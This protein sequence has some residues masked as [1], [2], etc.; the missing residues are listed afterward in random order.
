M[1]LGELSLYAWIVMASVMLVLWFIQ[2]R[3]L[4]AGTVDVAWAFGT[5]AVGVWFALYGQGENDTRQWLVA[6]L[7]A[8][9]GWRLGSFLFRR[10]TSESEDGRYRYLREY[11]GERANL[12]HFA[13]FQIQAAWTLLFALPIWAAAN[14]PGQGLEATDILA[15]VIWVVAVLGERTADNQLAQFKRDANSQGQVCDTGL[16]RWSRHPNYFFEWLHW[17]AYLAFAAQSDYWW[18]GLMG[19]G[20]V[21]VFVVYITGIPYTEQQ[22][23]RSKGAAYE[24]Y[25]ACTSRFFLWPPKAHVEVKGP[26]S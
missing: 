18:V 23:L 21:Y 7:S 5:G 12:F 9:W 6:A 15:V 8:L 19:L 13:F 24:D 20:V 2:T 4:N 25:Q 17:F 16:W 3:S 22:S 26:S 11:L 10:V 14:A 1:S